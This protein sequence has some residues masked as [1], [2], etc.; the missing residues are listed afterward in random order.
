MLF[1]LY[2]SSALSPA[3]GT[4][5][6]GSPTPSLESALPRPHMRRRYRATQPREIWRF[7][8]LCKLCLSRTA[9]CIW[10]HLVGFNITG[11]W[12][13]CDRPLVGGPSSVGCEDKLSS[14]QWHCHTFW[15][16]R[17]NDTN[18]LPSC[19]LNSRCTAKLSKKNIMAAPPLMVETFIWKL[20]F[21]HLSDSCRYL[22]KPSLKDLKGLEVVQKVLKR[23]FL[24]PIVSSPI[25]PQQLV[26]HYL[27]FVRVIGE[28][29][30]RPAATMSKGWTRFPIHERQKR[31]SIFRKQDWRLNDMTLKEKE[32]TVRG[33]CQ[34]WGEKILGKNIL[35]MKPLC[36]VISTSP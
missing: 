19:K 29:R 34:F 33:Y 16:C 27:P 23:P 12:F 22:K 1:L 7:L 31:K 8:K 3:P 11:C 24:L 20:Y 5:G 2:L 10:H 15:F 21:C 36:F 14:P 17:A 13:L 30:K 25:D 4:T 18:V 9:E 35:F 26:D 28:K 32:S 6:P